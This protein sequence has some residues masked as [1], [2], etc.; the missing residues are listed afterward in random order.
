MY[1]H[2]NHEYAGWNPMCGNRNHEYASWKAMYVNR[3]FLCGPH[4]GRAKRSGAF[5]D[6]STPY[7]PMH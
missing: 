6:L 2:R 3:F 7:N 5:S 4:V 1:T